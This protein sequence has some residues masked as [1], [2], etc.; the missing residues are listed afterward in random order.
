[1]DTPKILIVEDSAVTRAS[2]EIL[3]AKEKY[4]LHFAEDGLQGLE[5]AIEIEPDVILLDVMMPRMDGFE[6]CRKIRAM[7]LLAEIPILMISTLSDSRSRLTGLEAG[8]DD[9][10]PKPFDRLELKARLSS[11]TRLNRY[12]RIVYQRNELD[13]LHREL[14]VAYDE[15]IEGWADAL[16]LRDKETEGHTRRV[17]ARTVQ[18]ASLMGVPEDQKLHVWRGAMLHDVG[19]LGI[20]DAVLLKPGRLNDEEWKVMRQHPVYAHKWLSKIA[21]LR[22]ALDIPYCHHEKWDGSGYPRGLRGEEIPLVARIF[23]VIDVWDAL[24]N[25]RPYRAAQTPQQ[26]LEYLQEQSGCHFEPAAVQ[27]FL[28]CYVT[29][30]E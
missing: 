13:Q 17:T 5:K 25:D 15:T 18:L 21:Y 10:I 30:L 7:P 14:L 8:A 22:P 28:D 26:T 19:K 27:A 2:L 6:V 16:D 4:A 24:T 23:A 3:L 1:M 9:F 20:P 29:G 12:R 11:L